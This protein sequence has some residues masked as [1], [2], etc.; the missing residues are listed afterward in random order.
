MYL[1]QF[2]VFIYF[3]L[4]VLWYFFQ[5]FSKILYKNIF[6][7]IAVI[8]QRIM[9]LVN[10]ILYLYDKDLV[11]IH[12]HAYMLKISQWITKRWHA[13]WRGSVDQ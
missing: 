1:K 6:G 2:C 10:T 7:Q 12:T 11:Q 9:Q 5:H 8:G 3:W 4:N 13:S